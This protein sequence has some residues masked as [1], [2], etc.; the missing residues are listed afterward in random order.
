MQFHFVSIAQ[1]LH[2]RALLSAACKHASMCACTRVWFYGG[3][4]GHA[5]MHLRQYVSVHTCPSRKECARFSSRTNYCQANGNTAKGETHS[6]ALTGEM[7]AILNKQTAASA[8]RLTDAGHRES[9]SWPDCRSTRR[10]EPS[11]SQ[12]QAAESH[13]GAVDS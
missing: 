5:C 7:S 13:F 9:Y 12:K 6:P 11:P 10:S 1:L 3:C 8:L 2:K 4:C